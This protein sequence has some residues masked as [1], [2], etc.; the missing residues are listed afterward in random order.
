ME[1]GCILPSQVMPAH[2]VRLVP[3][4]KLGRRPEEQQALS[5]DQTNSPSLTARSGVTAPAS[6]QPSATT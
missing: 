3:R 4:I 6:Q 5:P 2:E 1:A